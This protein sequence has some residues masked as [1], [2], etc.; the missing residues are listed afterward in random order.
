MFSSFSI[1]LFRT[2]FFHLNASLKF[3]SLI[4]LILYLWLFVLS[5]RSFFS[6]KAP[7]P[8]SM[9]S[10]PSPSPPDF[11]FLLTTLHR[12]LPAHSCSHFQ[13]PPSVLYF[14]HPQK[15]AGCALDL[16]INWNA[17]LLQLSLEMPHFLVTLV[18][19]I[20]S[21]TYFWLFAQGSVVIWPL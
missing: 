5:I 7:R 3:M 8:G 11:Y 9:L 14:K 10:S 1:A 19:F 21:V 17:P 20:L 6:T 4:Y 15:S 13:G 12:G 16:V 18:C 2:L